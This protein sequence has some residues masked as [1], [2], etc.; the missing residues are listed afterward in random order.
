MQTVKAHGAI[1]PVIGLG[2]WQLSGETATTA[3]A[4]ALEAGYRHIDTAIGYGNEAE[5]GEGLRRSGI[6]RDDVFITSKIPPEQL[7]A[8]DMMRAAEASLR[9]LR[10]DQL[11]LILIHWP[12]RTLSSAETI[13]SLNRVK[14]RGLARHIGVSN[15]TIRLLDE[16]WAATEEPIVV[17]QCEHHPYLDQS[18]LRAATL[19]HGTA[20]VAYCPLG[21]GDVLDEPV[22]QDIAG[23]FG[24]TPAQ[25]VLR[26]QIQKG[27]VAI[28]KSA[29]AARIRQNLDIEGF[30]LPEA[31][32]AAIDALKTEGSR[33]CDSAFSPDWD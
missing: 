10:I 21:R 31:D 13:R 6:A 18:K 25:V 23:R 27:C 32:I 14:Q 11:D 33:M 3:V 16:A 12:S 17:N 26:W 20:F 8:D 7:G 9:R 4:S 19:A 1:L 5:V 29:H 24:R 30:E 22:I 2:T 15:Y 28:P